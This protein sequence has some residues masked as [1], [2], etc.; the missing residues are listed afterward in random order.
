MKSTSEGQYSKSK[1][2]STP[3]VLSSEEHEQLV[4]RF[5]IFPGQAIYIYSFK[6]NR[7]KF[8]SGWNELLG[9]AD[10]EIN[11][12]AIVSITT[13]RF[14][15]FS[16]ELND[17]ALQFILTKSEDLEDYSFT[18]ELEKFHKDGS[19]VPLFSRVAVY[20]A[21]NGHIE[22]IVGVSQR[23]DSL[24]LGGVMNYAAYGPD[25]SEFEENLNKELFRHYAIS[26]KEKE[27]LELAAQG[28]GFKEIAAK[29]NVSQSAIEKRIIPLYKRFEV[30][31]LP[32]LV[33]FAHK[34][35]IIE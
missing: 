19:I 35:N 12:L 25:K 10:D 29:C 34:N 31:S 18:L 4:K 2:T 17:K 8:A 11:M 15:P 23:I 1:I 7:M 16:N 3:V 5:N 14:A 13:P 20:K 32:H 28:F 6:E 24:K 22:E 9:Y 33:S 27:A 30:R 21:S 26:R